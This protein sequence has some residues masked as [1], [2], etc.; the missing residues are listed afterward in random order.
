MIQELL[1]D[2]AS[3]SKLRLITEVLVTEMYNPP[4]EVRDE[5]LHAQALATALEGSR[6][7]N[8]IELWQLQL[9]V[10]A[11]MLLGLDLTDGGGD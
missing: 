1:R 10:V 5:L 3:K 9:G 2:E 4:Q 11:K 6:P 8:H 7:L